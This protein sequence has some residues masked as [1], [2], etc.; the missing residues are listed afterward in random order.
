M[1]PQLAARLQQ[2][3]PEFVGAS[4]PL[5]LTAQAITHPEMYERTMTPLLADDS[6]G[7]LVLTAIV[8]SATDYALV[9]G[10][11]S[12]KPMLNSK[13]PVIFAML[14][15]EAEVP[16]KLVEEARGGNVPFFRSPERALR[17]LARITEYGRALARARNRE[18]IGAVSMP[19]LPG[20]G[21]LAEH[22]AKTYLAA[23][24]FPTPKGGLARSL[25]EARKIA[26]E[27]GFP[28]AA[29]LQA[30][31]LAHKS[32]FGG[33]LL[34]IADAPSLEAAWQKLQRVAAG[35]NLALDGILIEAMAERGVETIVGAR[36]DPQWGPVAMVGLGGIWAE[37]LGDIRI[38]PIGLDEDEIVVEI[39]KLRGAKLLAGMRGAKPADVAALARAVRLVGTIIAAGP[40]IA[41]IDINPF[42]VF[43]E[44]E[45]ALALDALIVTD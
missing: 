43:G 19:P 5:D 21:M 41:E 10:R 42:T 28:V 13:K 12:L 8:S 25:A 22:V 16:P 37:A 24:G 11:A 39:G 20:R 31:S 2:E 18:G 45:G 26:A 29:K 27:I 35:R 15:D 1:T 33:V 23:C 44:G 14:G 40:E 9:K 4:N 3:V 32:D 34:N 38:L 30:A 17:A 7:S 36:R 6:Y